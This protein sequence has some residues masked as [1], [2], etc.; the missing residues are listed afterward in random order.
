LLHGRHGLPQAEVHLSQRWIRYGARRIL[1]RLFG[2]CSR[3]PH[4]PC[5]N[6]FARQTRKNE[7][8]YVDTQPSDDDGWWANKSGPEGCSP[9]PASECRAA[10]PDSQSGAAP[11]GTR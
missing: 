5:R 4:D 1:L 2:A 11:H 6:L 9:A 3:S 7:G 8:V 10:G